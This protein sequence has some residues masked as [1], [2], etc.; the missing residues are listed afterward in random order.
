MGAAPALVPAPEC[1]VC[2]YPTEVLDSAAPFVC[3]L[4]MSVWDIFS[5][6]EAA[7]VESD[8]VYLLGKGFLVRAWTVPGMTVDRKGR[9]TLAATVKVGG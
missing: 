6:P 8:P 3:M 9:H 2:G 7:G 1:L 4:W 5:Q